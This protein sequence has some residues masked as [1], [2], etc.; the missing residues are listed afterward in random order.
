MANLKKIKQTGLL[1]GVIAVSATTFTGALVTFAQESN[2]S[3]VAVNGEK[4]LDNLGE[5]AEKPKFSKSKEQKKL[6]L[7]D[8]DEKVGEN[9][10]L[11]GLKRDDKLGNTKKEFATFEE[12]EKWAESKQKEG[13]ISSFSVLPVF[14][15]DQYV[16]SYTVEATINSEVEING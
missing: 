8:K 3:Q 14:W 13:K 11:E 6:K 12:A 4:P 9:V 1:A 7:Y 10:K 2:Q 16:H 15:S 5:I